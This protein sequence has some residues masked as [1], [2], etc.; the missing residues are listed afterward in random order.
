MADPNEKRAPRTDDV[1]ILSLRVGDTELAVVSAPVVDPVG[2]ASL[3]KAER[4]VLIRLLA[5]ASNAEIAAARGTSTR[6][7]GNQV[8]A[9]FQKLGVTSRSALAA[10]LSE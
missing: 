8:A 7:V 1:R 9:L 10:L 2:L 6:T 3:T 5:G 4:E